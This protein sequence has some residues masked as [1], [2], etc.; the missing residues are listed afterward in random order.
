MVEDPKRTLETWIKRS[1]KIDEFGRFAV[2]ILNGIG[3]WFTFLTAPGVEPTN[4]RAERA[5]REHVVQRKTIGTL[6][7]QKGKF[8]T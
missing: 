5:L 7:N 3:H 1:Y 4:H 2:K 6:R 8:H